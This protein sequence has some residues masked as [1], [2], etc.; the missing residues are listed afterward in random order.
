MKRHS[1]TGCRTE[2]HVSKSPS[3]PLV[4]AQ[5]H[6]RYVCFHHTKLQHDGMRFPTPTDGGSHLGPSLR[7]QAVTPAAGRV[8]PSRLA[9]K[10]ARRSN[11]SQVDPPPL[12]AAPALLPGL[13]HVEP[14]QPAPAGAPRRRVSHLVVEV[15]HGSHGAAAKP[16]GPAVPGPLRAL[17]TPPHEPKPRA[18]ADGPLPPRLRPG[19]LVQKRG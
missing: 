7:L 3:A 8:G 11:R 10:S 1:E 5:L 19:A 2:A 13:P 15:E 12:T 17:P 14:P 18:G 6:P 16:A 9:R 4:V